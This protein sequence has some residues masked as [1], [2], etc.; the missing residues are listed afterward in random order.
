[1]T[2]LFIR[3]H[4]KA[5]PLFICVLLMGKCS[6]QIFEPF[7]QR[8]MFIPSSTT[9]GFDNN[10]FDRSSRDPLY[11]HETSI[12]FPIQFGTST[13]LI[14]PD[15][16]YK[17]YSQSFNNW[18]GSFSEPHTSDHFRLVLKGVFPLD[19]TWNLL[20]LGGIAQGLNDGATLN[21]DQNF[22]RF[23]AGYLKNLSNGNQFGFA[24]Q[25]ISE[26]RLVVPVPVFKGTSRNKLWDFDVEGPRA[27]A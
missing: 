12:R 15:F 6:A 24:L 18:P 14:I 16:A 22:Y 4:Q 7:A 2:I 23:G 8:F 26:A 9:E 5:F 25:W 21:F 10:S 11:L 17:R 3:I 20:L 27:I 13:N 19:N 1:M